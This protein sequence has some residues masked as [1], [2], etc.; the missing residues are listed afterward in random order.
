MIVTL[1]QGVRDNVGSQFATSWNELHDLLLSSDLQAER[2]RKEDQ[3]CFAGCRFDGTRSKQNGRDACVI[4]LDVDNGWDLFDARAAAE[5]MLAPFVIYTTTKHT[6]DHHRFRIVMPLNRAVQGEEYEA[7]WRAI[8]RRLA[9]LGGELDA[10]TR[11]IS[12]LSLMP[13]RWTGEYADLD[14]TGADAVAFGRPDGIPIDVDAMIKA[15]PAPVEA[16]RAQSGELG[17]LATGEWSEGAERALMRRW[18][19]S[20]VDRATLADINGPLVKPERLEAELTATSGGRMYRFLCSCAVVARVGGFDIDASILE[21]LGRQFSRMVGRD[22]AGLK[23]DAKNAINYAR[24][25]V[26]A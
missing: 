24:R 11:D 19:N 12:R 21:D 2:S 22:T 26:V 8:E 17:T 10:K 23:V 5:D 15:H 16:R 18:R 14:Y 1:F 3:L 4:A 13:V 7:L 9:P 6:R 20:R 25:K